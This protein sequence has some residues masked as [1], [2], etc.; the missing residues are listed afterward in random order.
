MRSGGRWDLSRITPAE[1]ILCGGSLV[2]AAADAN[3]LEDAASVVTAELRASLWDGQ[4]DRSAVVLARFYRTV[5]FGELEPGLREF[6]LAAAGRQELLQSTKC[7]T[8]M[9]TAG[10]APE[11]NARKDSRR[12]RAIPLT[13]TEVVER[14]PMVAR[15]IR[16]LGMTVEGAVQGRWDPQDVERVGQG[17]VFYVQDAVGSEAVPDRDFVRDFGIRSVV[18]FGGPLKSGDFWAIILFTRVAVD[19]SVAPLFRF[20]ATDVKIGLLPVL[21]KRLFA[22]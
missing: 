17:R 2:R 10:E 12:H 3:S 16:D 1:I 21:T 14:L 18:G 20:L 8:L 6:A 22:A 9:G 11:W 13:S 19:P 7:L 4:A 5:D 15:L